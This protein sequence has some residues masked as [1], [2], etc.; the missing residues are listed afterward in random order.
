MT[1]VFI[2]RAVLQQVL[3]KLLVVWEPCEMTNA[4]QA[5]LAAPCEP[6]A[7][8]CQKANGHFDVLTDQTCKKC[9]PVY[10]PKEPT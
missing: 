4:L 9:F 8:L 10:A 6:V 7:Y 5:A 3:D 1:H 2:D